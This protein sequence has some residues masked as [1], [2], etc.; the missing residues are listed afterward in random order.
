MQLNI[1]FSIK[2]KRNKEA[3]GNDISVAVDSSKSILEHLT[4]L[5]MA[6]GALVN[7]LEAFAKTMPDGM[8]TE[9]QYEELITTPINKLKGFEV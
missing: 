9:K 4:A 6:K 1:D 8:L 2:C 7:S 5:E 3:D